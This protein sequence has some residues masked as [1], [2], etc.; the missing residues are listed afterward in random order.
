[1]ADKII[2]L[3]IAELAAKLGKVE[4]KISAMAQVK[5]EQLSIQAHS[6]IINKAQSELKGF[7]LDAFLGRGK[8]DTPS[9]DKATP[10]AAVSGDSKYVKW[11]KPMDGI[12]QVAIDEK[13]MK[14]EEGAPSRSMADTDWLLKPGKVKYNKKGE[15]YRIIPMTH[16]N[17]GKMT[18]N[19]EHVNTQIK[20]A[21]QNLGLKMHKIE[22]DDEGQPK[23]GVLHKIKLYN[24]SEWMQSTHSKPRTAEEANLSGLKPH[25]GHHILK[26]A[27]VMQSQK[28]NRKGRVTGTKRETVTFR[29]VHEKHKME[30]RWMAPAIK[31]LH[32]IEAAY[33]WANSQIDTIM[34]S[35]IDELGDK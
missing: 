16:S 7:H 27:L 19:N 31:P 5:M 10:N 12:W 24:D 32:S 15:A 21:Y 3:D 35:I 11:I 6:F 23:L 8:N 4:K 13:A 20:Q 1:M 14:Y 30:N 34:Q 22:K 2:I 17:R 9:G 33:D 18:G 28:I 25:G 26:D 29:I